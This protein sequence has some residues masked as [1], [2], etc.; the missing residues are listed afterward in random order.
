M[1]DEVIKKIEKSISELR[2]TYTKYHNWEQ[3]TKRLIN[4]FYGGLA[5][6][7]MYFFNVN[8]AECITV[9]GKHAILYAESKINEYFQNYWYDDKETHKKMGVVV[10]KSIIQP[11]TVYI[12]TDSVYSQL[13]EI[14]SSTDWCVGEEK[15]WKITIE[16]KS[17]K[18]KERIFCG[19]RTKEEAVEVL[20]LDNPDIDKYSF[21]KVKGEE[22]DFAIV[23]DDV[24][25]TDYFKKIFDEYAKTLNTENYLKFE[26]ESYSDA[27]IW[28]CKKKYIQNI[29]WTDSIPRGDIL[30]NYSKIKPSGIEIV[31][32]SSPSFARK[33]LM[34][35]V[36]WI[37]SHPK[38][39]LREFVNELRLIKDELKIANP[40]DI[41]WNKKASDYM[42][43]I[44]DD[45]KEL[46]MKSGTPIT[47]K[48]IAYYNYILNN[49][50][51]Y[52]NRYTNLSSGMK[53]K[54]YYCLNDKCN[55]FAYE[56][57]MFPIEFAPEI[58]RNMMFE[59]TILTPINRIV[60]AIGF[61]PIESD[62]IILKT[63][64]LF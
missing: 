49:N 5:N 16:Y 43:W 6:P 44:V 45:N 54:Y 30:K 52:K 20:D 14:I 11:V 24:F 28:L 27:G 15:N 40:D 23:L 55:M 25:L 18:V 38:F 36:R 58:D 32:P 50:A 39:E 57:G 12:D 62:L 9:Q 42:K 22:K 60:E 7:Y 51:K 63:L 61:S 37:F 26:L 47:T 56:P 48:G 31:Q 3:G 59:K 46:V 29:R 10:Y 1:T 2:D 13:D 53:C 8:L 41:S 64:K 19:K 17:G 34:Y 33:K 35:L 4:S 21:E